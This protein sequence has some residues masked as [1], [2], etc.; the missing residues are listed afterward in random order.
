MGDGRRAIGRRIK[1]LRE[2]S[3]LSRQQVATRLAVDLTAVAA[4][5]AG[6]YLPREGR[7]VRLAGLLGIDIASLFAEQQETA[8]A[9][10]ATLI[11]TLSELPGLLRELLSEA[12]H[13]LRA[14]RLAA[15][16]STPANV[17]EE[18]RGLVDSRLRAG[19]LA[20]E[21][22]EIF[23]DLQRLKEVLSNMLRYRDRPYRVRTAC[24]GVTEV[25]PGMGGYFFD[26]TEFLLGA[27]W[28]KV[29]PFQR[30]GLRLSGEPY[31]TYFAGYWDEIWGR[32]TAL[33]GDDGIDVDAVREVAVR[34][35]LEPER[36]PDFLHEAQALEIGDGLPPL[37]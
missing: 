33:N 23:Y 35:G 34:L 8:L 28:A 5:E 27:Y 21:R 31:K 30:A 13:R 32:G 36:W 11:D 16:Y 26:D 19:T 4:W 20:V 18:F 15:P 3:G 29:P 37:I 10:G 6:K 1:R 7:R 25:V 9:N 24:A 14:F 17:Q 12:E 2:N 22:I